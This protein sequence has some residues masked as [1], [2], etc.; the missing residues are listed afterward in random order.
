MTCGG[1]IENNADL[2]QGVFD[3]LN[4]YGNCNVVGKY[5]APS[6]TTPDAMSDEALETAKKMAKDI[7]N[8]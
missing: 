6:C 4:N 2:I 3:R 8:T 1:P 5:V 7:T